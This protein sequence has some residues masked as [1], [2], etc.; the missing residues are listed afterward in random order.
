MPQKIWEETG[1]TPKSGIVSTTSIQP[2]RQPLKRG[3][4]ISIVA[5]LLCH[6]VLDEP[7]PFPFVN[8]LSLEEFGR[9]IV[10]HKVMLWEM[11]VLCVL[12]PT[13]STTFTGSL[14]HTFPHKFVSPE[15]HYPRRAKPILNYPA[16]SQ[17]RKCIAFS[18]GIE[19]VEIVD[20][21]RWLACMNRT[22]PAVFGC[23]QMRLPCSNTMVGITTSVGVYGTSCR[24][25]K[26]RS[27]VCI[28]HSAAFVAPVVY[29]ILLATSVP[30]MENNSIE[31][32]CTI[33]R[34]S[35]HTYLIPSLYVILIASW[36]DFGNTIHGMDC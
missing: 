25:C 4:Y 8:V 31:L 3:K 19:V 2:L 13:P 14:R 26:I 12:S 20:M 16:S 17:E 23:E 5:Q 32:T 22:L 10:C 35:I 21:N 27:R 30:G 33:H 1:I 28:A 18:I 9:Y 34:L 7:A 15:V 29:V 36:N 6:E 11:P 24:D